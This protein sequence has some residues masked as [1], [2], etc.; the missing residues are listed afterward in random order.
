MRSITAFA[1]G[2]I[3]C[4][5][6]I[7]T[8][9]LPEKMH[10]LGL[11]FTTSEGVTATVSRASNPTISLNGVTIEMPP[12]MT[13]LSSLSPEPIRVELETP[14]PVSYGFGVSGASCLATALAVNELL[15]LRLSRHDVA[16]YAHTA[17]VKHLTGLGDVCSQTI[18]GCVLRREAGKPLAGE[19]LPVDECP[20][21]Y[22]LFGPIRSASVLGNAQLRETIN[23]A[24]DRALERISSA[25]EL[26]GEDLF[27]ALVEISRDFAACSNL[28]PSDELKERLKAL[29]ASSVSASMIMLGNALFALNPFPGCQMTYL[30]TTAARVMA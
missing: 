18:A 8:N 1:P 12:L 15:D 4:V 14:L 30:G 6:R 26:S 28:L 16:L 21:Y 22:K 7:I 5:F 3:S 2:N 29:T 20:I 27:P 11:A 17:E 13:V 9:P 24:G 25:L 10:S 19:R 23:N